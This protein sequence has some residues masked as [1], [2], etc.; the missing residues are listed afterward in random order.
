M[1]PLVVVWFLLLGNTVGMDQKDSITV[2]MAVAYA[3]LVLLVV[4]LA[5][6]SSVVVRP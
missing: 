2:V 3:R 6:F 5:L 1:S 4:H